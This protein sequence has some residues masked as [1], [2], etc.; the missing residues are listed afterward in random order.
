MIYEN[1][2]LRYISDG[3]NEIIRMIYPAV[4]DRE[5]LT[6]NPEITAETIEVNESSFRIE[7]KCLYNNGEINF[8]A[9]YR[10]EGK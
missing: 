2:N 4:R 6:I 8:S 9:R 7:Y 1:G 3:K 10:I 5:W